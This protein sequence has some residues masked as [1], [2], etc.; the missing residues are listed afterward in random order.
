MLDYLFDT[1]ADKDLIERIKSKI[2]ELPKAREARFVSQYKIPAYDA[3]VLTQEKKI[4]DFFEDA[5]KIGTL[6]ENLDYNSVVCLFMGLILQEFITC[7]NLGNG[8][9]VENLLDLML[10]GI[11]ANNDYLV[12][13]PVRSHPMK[14]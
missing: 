11:G 13:Y 14:I 7:M 5:A 3:A 8:I 1:I 9:P 10:N 12:T 4:A 6:R 2:P